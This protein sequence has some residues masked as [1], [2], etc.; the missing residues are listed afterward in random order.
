ML[1]LFDLDGTLMDDGAAEQSAATYLYKSIVTPLSLEQFL[2]QWSVALKRHFNRYLTGEVSFQGQRRDRVREVI[3]SSLS[4]AAADRMF[5]DYH[6]NYEAAW[7][8]FPDVMPC[9]NSLSEFR[10][11]LI[12]N[13]QADQQRRKLAQTCILDRFE[14]VLIS[15]ECGCAKPD[16][17]IFIRACESLG[18]RPESSVYIGDRYDIDAQAARR[19]GLHGI[20]LDR[21]QTA[22][23]SHVPPIIGSLDDLL[24]TL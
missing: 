16:P 23:A 19:A 5:A 8:L 10:V 21:K 18:E 3:D 1:I 15:E 17:A 2:S 20:W 13:G 24:T 11:G 12:T 14:C 22:N 4:D 9:L 7:T 6:A